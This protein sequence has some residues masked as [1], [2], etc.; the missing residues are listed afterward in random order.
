MGCKC[1]TCTHKDPTEL[2]A[3]Y[4]GY[5]EACKWFLNWAEEN[6]IKMGSISDDDLS[7]IY[8]QIDC[9]YQETMCLLKEAKKQEEL[10]N[11]ELLVNNVFK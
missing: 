7:G 11:L 8:A 6:K 2:V 4:T 9:N 1:F 5:V 3:Y 10:K